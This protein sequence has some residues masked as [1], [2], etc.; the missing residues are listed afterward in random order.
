MPNCPVCSEL[1]GRCSD[2][3]FRCLA[4]NHIFQYPAIVECVYDKEYVA[5]RYDVYEMT[6]LMSYLRLGFVKSFVDGGKLLDVGYGNGSFL[7]LAAKNGFDVYGKD[8][9]GADYGIRE[10]ELSAHVWNLVTFFD[11]LEHFP[12][13]ISVREIRAE[14]IIVST[15]YRPV[16]FPNDLSWKHYRPG[17]HLHYFSEN[18][19]M[20][21]FLN[22]N[23]V[24]SFMVE[25]AVRGSRNGEPNILTCVF[26]ERMDSELG[27][28]AY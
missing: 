23:F 16:S 24:G 5:T 27:L 17:E 12:D 22:M 1:A 2:M 15:P 10:I 7:K 26:S 14:C 4:C 25:D 21:L 9:H 6:L 18:S 19:L 20:T 11:S 8:V 3:L 13:L 28:D